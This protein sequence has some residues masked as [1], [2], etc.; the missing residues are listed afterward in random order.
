MEWYVVLSIV[1]LVVMAAHRHMS[2]DAKARSARS[3]P[4]LVE[5]STVI[6]MRTA[7]EYC[8]QFPRWTPRKPPTLEHRHYVTF[9]VLDAGRDVQRREFLV[10]V[11]D[12]LALQ[13]GVSGQ[14]MSRGPLYWRFTPCG[15]R[16]GP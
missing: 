2:L 7:D 15:G 14:L 3:H 12:Y 8:E 13:I 16:G 5:H 11:E 1:A 10:P 6:A 4:I 9:E